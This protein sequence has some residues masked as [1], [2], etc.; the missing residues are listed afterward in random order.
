MR[1][2]HIFDLDDTLV[3]YKK[4]KISVPKQ[5]FHILRSAYHCVTFAVVTFNLFAKEI[6]NK[7]GLTKYVRYVVIGTQS[8]VAL[9]ATFL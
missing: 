8:R 7:T 2:L 4:N 6:V 9:L 1:V 3:Q 5:T